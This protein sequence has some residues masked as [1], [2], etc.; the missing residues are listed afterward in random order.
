MKEILDIFRSGHH[1]FE[2]G[3]MDNIPQDSAFVLFENWLKEAYDN[4]IEANA[5]QLST[6]SPTGSPSSRIVYLKDVVDESYVFYTNYNSDKGKAIE[7][8]PEVCMSFFWPKTARQI[9]I[10][11]R[12]SKLAK[13]QSDAY[14]E[15]R[16]RASQIGAWASEQSEVIGSREILEERIQAFENRFPN[17]VPRPPH[18]GGYK[19]TPTKFEFWQGRKSRLHDR[20]LFEIE[21][22]EWS[23]YRKSP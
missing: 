9:H 7:K 5:F 12:C 10:T 20:V 4:E 23:A 1:E 11:G 17:V 19:V 14:F 13:E 18:W 16:P 8:N 15:S 6:I 2:N 3:R 21:S 22:N